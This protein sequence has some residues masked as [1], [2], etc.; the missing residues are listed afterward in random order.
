MVDQI[1]LA[2]T[3]QVQLLQVDGAANGTLE[4]AGRPRLRRQIF[5]AFRVI[6][7]RKSHLDGAYQAGD[8]P[9][10]VLFRSQRLPFRWSA[11]P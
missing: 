4:N 10:V 1:R 11:S 7:L 8:M 6:I 9:H 5:E 2:I 3:V